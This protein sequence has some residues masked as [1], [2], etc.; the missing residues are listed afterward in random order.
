MKVLVTGGAGYVGTVVSSQLLQ[1]GHE[2]VVLDSLATSRQDYVP[3]GA[4]FVRGDVADIAKLFSRHDGLEAVIHCAGL[5]AAGESMADPAPYWQAN[6]SQSL[7][8]LAGMR[9][10][11]IERLIFSSTAAVYGNPASQ[12]I[13]ETASTNPTNVYGMTKLV[14][15]Q[16]IASYCQAYGLAAISLRYFNVAGAEGPHGERHQHET[17]LIP[18]ALAAAATAKPFMVYGQDYPTDDGTCIRDYIHVGDLARGHLLAL[19]RLTA[20]QHAIYNLGSGSGYSVRQIVEAINA[21]TH[22]QL[23]IHFGQRRA[24]D[25]PKLV[26]DIDKA[27]RQLGWRPHKSDLARIIADAWQFYQH[28]RVS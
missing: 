2:V 23:D 22:K 14:I 9:Q 27:A 18:L 15:D 16:A 6:T 7:S 17:H 28:G 25:P 24:G 21:V 13:A 1:A 20:G 19:D 3:V 26:A 8:L 10:L 11:G 5:I 12:P 4:E